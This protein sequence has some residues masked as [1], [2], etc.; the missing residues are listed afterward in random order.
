M[1][2]SMIRIQDF[3][4]QFAERF[5]QINRVWLEAYG[6]LEGH[7]Q[8]ILDD[9]MGYIQKKGGDIYLAME[10]EE[11]VGTAALFPTAEG[12]LELGKMTVLPQWRGRGIARLLLDHC[13]QKAREK[14]VP[15]LILYSN[16]KLQRAIGIYEK[17]G[18]VHLV[19]EGGPYA[20]AD[21]KMIYRFNTTDV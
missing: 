13:L 2:N 3:Q 1:G 20:T 10:G 5:S 21:I 9:P 14:G 18:F 12:E 4:E 7:D 19:P 11:V 16:S 6:L 17:A 8:M 15:Y